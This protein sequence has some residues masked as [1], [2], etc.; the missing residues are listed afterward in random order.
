MSYE[1]VYQTGERPNTVTIYRRDG[2]SNLYYRIWDPVAGSWKRRSLKHGDLAEAKTWAKEQAAKLERGK[3]HLRKGQ[4][5]LKRLFR[6]YRKQRSPEKSESQRQVDEREAELWKRVL[7][8]EKVPDRI[9]SAEW[10]GFIEQ[11]AS[12][13]IDARG[14]PVAEDDRR[15]VKPRTVRIDCN[16]L[17]AVMN[18]AKDWR[19][20]GGYLL[21]QNP[22]RGFDAPKE[23]NPRRVVA[24]QEDY[25]RLLAVADRVM[26]EVTWENETG[27]DNKTKRVR[28]H[29]RELLVIANGTG[30]RIGAICALR[31]EDLLPDEGPHGSLRWRA[32]ED[33]EDREWVAPISREV[34][35]AVDRARRRP[36]VG[37]PLFPAARDPEKAISRHFA[38]KML[39]RAETEAEMEHR[40]GFGWHAFRRKWVTE[41][42]HHPDAD[43]AAAGGWKSTQAVRVAYQ[44]ADPDTMYEVVT[45]GGELRRVDGQ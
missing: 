23:K 26:M 24:T 34:R 30:R 27:P 41:R 9:T 42:K 29:F 35:K 2:S 1:Q 33:K 31:S 14:H 4:V 19:T 44:H 43:V 36:P 37:G 38:R 17:K 40:H 22:I 10:K 7:G 8:P 16:W 21:D 20:E 32:D 5:T 13:E 12:G 3:S 25:D 11:R 39:R 15:P 6:L 45:G 28:S 18:W